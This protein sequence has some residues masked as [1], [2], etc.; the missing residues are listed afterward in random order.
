[1]PFRAGPVDVSVLV[2]DGATGEHVPEARVTVRLTARESGKVREYPATAQ[3]ATNQLF[4]AA[5]FRLPEPGWW[6]VQVAVE[7][8]HGPAVVRF[9]V[10]ADEPP[11]PWLEFWPW[12][13]WPAF[14]VALFSLHR[15]LVRQQQQ[16]RRVRG[17]LPE[18]DSAEPGE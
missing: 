11:P 16:P 4:Q 13:T 9:E 8:P 3:A 1:T 12:F 5:V 18:G 6:D 2:L 10:E 17:G 7:G 14:A 15:V